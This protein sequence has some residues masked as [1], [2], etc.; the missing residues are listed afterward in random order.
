MKT[1][2]GVCWSIS[3]DAFSAWQYGSG[4]P[5][6]AGASTAKY[7]AAEAGF[8]ACGTAVMTL[9]G[10]GYAKEYHVERYLRE[11]L[12]PASRRSARSSFFATS[13]N[14]CSACPSRIDHR[15]LG[16]SR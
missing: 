5:C 2:E 8:K 16:A 13:P 12:I 15:F 10:F 3:D 1:A 14:A 7:L 6:G 11:I 9:G 4:L